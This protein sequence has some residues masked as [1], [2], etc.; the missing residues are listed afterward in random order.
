MSLDIELREKT[1]RNRE[2]EVRCAE[3]ELPHWEARL[4]CLLIE[5]WGLVAAEIDG[6]D[7]AGRSKLRSMTPEEMV[8]RACSTAA[9]AVAE[10]RKRGWVT[11]TPTFAEQKAFLDALPTE[12]DPVTTRR[13]K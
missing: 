5:K 6:E 9:L 12:D 10:I 13:P 2:V 1:F 8:E 4:A 7:S 11:M 3:N